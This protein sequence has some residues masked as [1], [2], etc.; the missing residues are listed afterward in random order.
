MAAERQPSTPGRLTRGTRSHFP[1]GA[2]RDAVEAGVLRCWQRVL[3]APKS[4][5]GPRTIARTIS[6]TGG[7]A[8]GPGRWVNAA[9]RQR[10]VLPRHSSL[11]PWGGLCLWMLGAACGPVWAAPALQWSL[12]VWEREGEARRP[13]CMHACCHTWC[14]H[15]CRHAWCHA[16]RY[17]QWSAPVPVPLQPDLLRHVRRWSAEQRPLTRPWSCRDDPCITRRGCMSQRHHGRVG[18]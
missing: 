8:G 9:L 2:F 12:E 6:A 4:A 5:R 10:V 16:R 7:G 17:R 11:R 13:G 14:M 15:P 18:K 3:M 1:A